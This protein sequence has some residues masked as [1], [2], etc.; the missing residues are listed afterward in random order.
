VH[1]TDPPSPIDHVA[2]TGRAVPVTK[3]PG[4][5]AVTDRTPTA[6]RLTQYAL[7]DRQL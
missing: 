6:E 7:L 1:F 4:T 3:T 5:E 2:S